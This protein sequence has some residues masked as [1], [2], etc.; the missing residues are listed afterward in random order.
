MHILKLRQDLE[1]SQGVRIVGSV[2]VGERQLPGST[3][4]ARESVA[5]PFAGGRHRLIAC[6][7]QRS[8]GGNASEQGFEHRTNCNALGH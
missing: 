8:G 6:G 5:V 2:V 3:R 4:Q 7:S 1:Q